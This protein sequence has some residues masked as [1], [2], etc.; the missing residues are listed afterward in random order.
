MEEDRGN[1]G[2]FRQ[3]LLGGIS[4]LRHTSQQ[5]HVA[6]VPVDE[7][8]KQPIAL[9]EYQS[10]PALQIPL[11]QQHQSQDQHAV[12]HDKILFQER[13]QQQ[14]QE[15]PNPAAQEPQKQA[16]RALTDASIASP[17]VIGG[18]ERLSGSISQDPTQKEVGKAAV[19]STEPAEQPTKKTEPQELAAEKAIGVSQ[20]ALQ[21]IETKT[22][23][24]MSG[25]K[26]VEADTN[27]SDVMQPTASTEPTT[28]IPTGKKATKRPRAK[29][30]FGLRTSRT[31]IVETGQKRRSCICTNSKLCNELMT[32][33]AKVSPPDYHCKYNNLKS[34]CNTDEL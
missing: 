33:W 13:N 31:T 9:K 27:Q 11:D 7:K 22:N 23:D 26:N 2:G 20:I 14:R 4:H 29:P 24:P 16:E 32:K 30:G 34:F 21:V 18:S 10:Q 19:D 6:M 15:G 12:D 28:T 1:V 17:T 3:N 8:E 25:D 5:L